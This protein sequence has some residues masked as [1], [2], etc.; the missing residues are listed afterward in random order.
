MK[1]NLSRM[2]SVASPVGTVMASLLLAVGS[3]WAATAPAQID[4]AVITSPTVLQ[5][6]GSGFGTVRPVVVLGGTPLYL[7]SFT[8]TV[9]FASVPVAVPAGS[10]A[11][12]ITPSG[13]KDV[14]A[15]FDVTIGT[16]GPAG[17]TG[18]AG[19]MGTAGV[20]GPAG[21]MGTAGV[22]GPAGP[23]G[24]AGVTG[25]AGAQGSTGPAGVQ[26]LAGPTGAAGVQGLTGAP[27]PLGPAGPQGSIG[28][29]GPAG[30]AGA[31]G[32]PGTSHL[33]TGLLN[34]NTDCGTFGCFCPG[35]HPHVCRRLWRFP[36]DLIW[37]RAA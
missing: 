18:P 5:I 33:Y 3:T 11:L 24:P 31:T 32:L 1:I 12:V 17:A 7:L 10:Y 30:P 14:S 22:T 2:F 8:D 35:P 29:Q 28:P 13:G 4:S 16:T 9:V 34:A 26:G 15:P 36:P 27:G 20:A 37:S 25:P 23:M 21:P 6:D 19:P